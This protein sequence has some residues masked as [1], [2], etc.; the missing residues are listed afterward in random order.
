MN[1]SFPIRYNDQVITLDMAIEIVNHIICFIEEH[2]NC[3]LSIYRTALFVFR[4]LCKSTRGI[5]DHRPSKEDCKKAIDV[6]EQIIN[7][8]AD[9]KTQ[10]LNRTNCAIAKIIIEKFYY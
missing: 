6:L 3:N 10:K 2:F 8:K 1:N 5:N 7:Y 9:E 4:A